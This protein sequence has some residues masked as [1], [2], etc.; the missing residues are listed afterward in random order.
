MTSIVL[1]WRLKTRAERRREAT[2]PLA[3]EETPETNHFI[4]EAE[5][6][7]SLP[8]H[9]LDKSYRSLLVSFLQHDALR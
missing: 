8:T 7:L 1:K 2:S 3:F 5:L 4:V 6:I 9:T